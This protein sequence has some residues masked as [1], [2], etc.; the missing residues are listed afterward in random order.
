MWLTLLGGNRKGNEFRGVMSGES[1][2][3]LTSRIGLNEGFYMRAAELIPLSEGMKVLDMG[4]GTGSLGIAIAGMIGGSGRVDCVDISS[5]QLA[6]AE[7]KSRT[8]KTPFR[9]H[10]CSM[11]E[12]PFEDDQYDAVV[13]CFSFHE[14]ASRVR[15]KAVGEA[16]RLLR[17]DGVFV[18]IEWG[19]PQPA[20]WVLPWIPFLLI[21]SCL[22]N[23]TNKYAFLCG[24]AGMETVCDTYLNKLVR[25]QIFRKAGHCGE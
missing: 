13:S 1:Y 23:W 2:D 19:R 11:D 9:F 10:R 16:A 14:A 4:C 22:D 25:C 7:V 3:R 8:L 17:E 6:H 24:E 12:T 21:D 15:R 5:E 18:L 20:L